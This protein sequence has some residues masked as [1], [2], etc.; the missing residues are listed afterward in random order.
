MKGDGFR[1]SPAAGLFGQGAGDVFSPSSPA[2]D[3]S[4]TGCADNDIDGKPSIDSAFFVVEV[5]AASGS[6]VFS[7]SFHK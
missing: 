4:F 7:M 5:D 2:L 1:V 3:M 6:S